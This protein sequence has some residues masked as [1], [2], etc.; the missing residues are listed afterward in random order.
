MIMS[1]G[2]GKCGVNRDLKN[3]YYRREL[4]VN[5]YEYNLI[6]FENT[7]TRGLEEAENMNLMHQ[8]RISVIYICL[9]SLTRAKCSTRS[10]LCWKVGNI[11]GSTELFA[12]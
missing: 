6:Y 10:T 9:T 11:S 4:T 2:R 12:L 5:I 1:I 8:Q 7:E 3:N